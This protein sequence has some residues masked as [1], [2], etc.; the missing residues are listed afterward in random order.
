[1][2]LAVP[3]VELRPRDAVRRV[4]GVEIEGKPLDRGA[5]PVA[6][7]RRPLVG[8]VAERSDVVAPDDDAVCLLVHS[9][10]VARST[11]R[12]WPGL[13]KSRLGNIDF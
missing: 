11:P 12:H 9:A 1:V 2:V 8:D 4:F 10:S 5:E 7:P 13:A 3:A 6:E